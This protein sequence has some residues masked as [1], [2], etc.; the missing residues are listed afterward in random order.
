M[1]SEARYIKMKDSIRKILLLDGENP[2]REGLVDTPD[3]VE[4]AHKELFSGYKTEV[5]C[6]TF[7][8]NYDQIVMLD[9][10]EFYSHCEHHMIPFYGRAHI[11]YIPNGKTIG[12]SKLARL[13]DKYAKRYQIQERMTEEITTELTKALGEPLGVAVVVEGIH[14]CIRARGVQKQN[15][16]MKTAKMTGKFMEN[17]HTRAEFYSLLNLPKFN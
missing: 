13:V 12:I 9:N 17:V 14:M 6:T 7:D 16:I 1:G 8:E 11:A 10:I 15:S 3:R 4:R 5:K 2:L